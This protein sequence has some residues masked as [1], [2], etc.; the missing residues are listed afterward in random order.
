M[1]KRP[2]VTKQLISNLVQVKEMPLEIY[3]L[4]I[5]SFCKIECEEL[6][7]PQTCE[8]WFCEVKWP[9]D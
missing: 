6:F 9:S 7:E 1:R 3:S 4:T 5:K 2:T 8:I